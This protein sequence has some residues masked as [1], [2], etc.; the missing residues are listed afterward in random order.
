MDEKQF[1]ILVEK[2]DKLSRIIVV[3]VIKDLSREQDKIE[4]LDSVGFKSG[5]IGKML[6]KSPANVS[7][8]LG[9]IRKKKEPAKQDIS[10]KDL[11]PTTEPAPGNEEATK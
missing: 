7:T 8:V 10:A 3:Q 4:L 11:E 5:E 2:M 9:N 1:S 6:G